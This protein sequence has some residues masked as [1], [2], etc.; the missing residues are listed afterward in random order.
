[1]RGAESIDTPAGGREGFTLL[2]VL[3]AM[4]IL[5]FVILGVQASMTDRMV[6]DVGWQET[7]V[8]ANQLALDRV[9]AIQADP[10]YATLSTRYAGTERGLPGAPTFERNTRFTA[11]RLGTGSEYLTITVT[12]SEPRLTRPVSRTVVVASP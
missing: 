12:V 2:E 6:R 4:V 9:H 3:V 5:G 1:M 11:T 7:R 10:V 8:R